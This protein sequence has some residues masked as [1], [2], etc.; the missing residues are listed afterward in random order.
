M[1]NSM[2]TDIEICPESFLEISIADEESY[3]LYSEIS[4]E[5]FTGIEFGLFPSGQR[6]EGSDFKT[7]PGC[8][9][10]YSCFKIFITTET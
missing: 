1:D 10:H 2:F 9:G 5:T 4:Q 7:T 6:N 3:P 8:L